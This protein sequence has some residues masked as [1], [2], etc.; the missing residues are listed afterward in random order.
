MFDLNEIKQ[1]SRSKSYQLGQQLYQS[2]KV[3]RLVIADDK[4]TAVVSGQYDYQVTLVKGSE[5]QG[6]TLQVSCSCPAAEYQDICKHAVAVALSVENTPEEELVN[7]AA[8]HVQLKEWFK[9]K[10]VDELT[11]IVMSYIDSSPDEQDKWQLTMGNEENRLGASEL[12]KLITKALPAKQVWEWDKVGHYFA[13]AEEMFATI[14]PAIEKLAI[15]KQWQLTLKALQRLNKVLE[16]IDDSGGFRF[17]LE[18][19]FNEKVVALFNQLP[20]SDEK[21]AQWIFSHVE[22]YKY[23]VFPDV[24]D[25]F[26]LTESV[27]QIL[28]D[29]CLVAAEH[30]AQSG[31]LNDWEHKWAIQRLTQPLIE[32]AKQTG[33]WREQCRLMKMSALSHSDYL[34]IADICLDNAAELDAENWL[35]QA[36]QKATTPY[37]KALCQE[38]EVKVRIALAEYKSAWQLAWQ[39]FTDNP[40]FMAYKKLEKLQQQT[41]EIDAQ[42]VK[43]AEQMFSDAYVETDHGLPANADALLDFYIDRNELEKARLWA[44]SHKANS[45]SLI[46]LADLIIAQHPD[47]SVE[48]YHRVAGSII[49]QTNNSA[50]QEATDLLLKLEKI[51]KEKNI[52]C[53]LLH[54]MIAKII[55]QHKQKRNMMKL[56][57]EHF[58][59]C[60]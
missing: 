56:L 27:R 29:K 5:I 39:I 3:S 35:Q 2:G 10:S 20:W 23:D 53:A 41:G 9:Q 51:L 44:L 43:K 31:D 34:A 15:T 12:S 11:D 59:D 47:D 48:L 40:S 46:K 49:S 38:Y 7:E 17:Q 37:E 4:V 24:P 54:S 26:D 45:A 13:H 60:F 14:F 32:L 22:E 18:S 28:L 57:K 36:Y 21:K 25:D 1:R 33:N 58:G 6:E 16:Q 52:D 19:Q 55:K 42:F 50:Y 30:K 8:G